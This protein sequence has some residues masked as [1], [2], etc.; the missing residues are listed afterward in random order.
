MKPRH[1]PPDV[2]AGAAAAFQAQNKQCPLFAVLYTALLLRQ[3]RA[4]WGPIDQKH[5]EARSDAVALF[6][7]IR[8]IVDAE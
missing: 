3:L 2:G 5:A 7:K 8:D 6:E 4:E 1:W